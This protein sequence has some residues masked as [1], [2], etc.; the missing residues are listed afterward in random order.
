VGSG[1][2]LHAGGH[3]REGQK[4]T[5][6]GLLLEPVLLIFETKSLTRTWSVLIQ[7]GRPSS[8]P[9]RAHCLIPS[10]GLRAAHHHT[11]PFYVGIKHRPPC[12][13]GKHFTEPSRKLPRRPPAAN[14]LT[15]RTEYNA[16]IRPSVTDGK[17]S[18]IPATDI[19]N[20]KNIHSGVHLKRHARCRKERGHS[21]CVVWLHLL[22][23]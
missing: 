5:S 10:P 22:H 7:P 11:Q 18:L 8:K 16:H 17:G 4:S 15:A 19:H 3:A 13:D 2:H 1:T 9:Q 6:V 21:L 14:C 23:T 20:R 12:L